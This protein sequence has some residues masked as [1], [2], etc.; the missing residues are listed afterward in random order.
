MRAEGPVLEVSHASRRARP[1]GEPCE[2]KEK[3]G[4]VRPRK[5]RTYVFWLM[6]NGQLLS[7]KS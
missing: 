4:D 3:N 6:A 1:R 2:P 7:A 5:R